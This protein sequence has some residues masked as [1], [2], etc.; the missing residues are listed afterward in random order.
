MEL[1]TTLSKSHATP[2][3]QL[4]QLA[5]ET[6]ILRA[7]DLS[8][9]GIARV[10]LKP[11]VESGLLVQ[12]GRGLYALADTEVSEYQ[13]LLEA[14]A[15]APH[16]VIALVSALRFHGLTTQ[17]P[18]KIWMLLETGS[19][20]PQGDYPSLTIFQAK[21]DSFH[22]GIETHTIEGKALR[23]TCIAKTVV[24]CFKYR[25]KI[26]LDVALEALKECLTERRATHEELR[27]YAKICRVE[28]VMAPYIEAYSI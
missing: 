6:G 7:R 1:T 11:L 4:A 2:R 8:A 27:R 5:Q 13:T 25:N 10:Y 24:D 21:G 19:H 12:L 18:W 23:V 9:R 22:Q 15:R 28:R 14:M 17:N 16:G 3:E 26:G 20:V